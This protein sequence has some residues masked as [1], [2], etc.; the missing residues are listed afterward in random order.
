MVGYILLAI[1]LA[2]WACFRLI[3]FPIQVKKERAVVRQWRADIN[4]RIADAQDR[5]LVK[6]QPS[7]K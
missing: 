6:E 5:K 1:L 7:D 3:W 4:A 2:L